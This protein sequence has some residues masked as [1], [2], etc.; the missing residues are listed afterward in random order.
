MAEKLALTSLEVDNVLR[1]KAVRLSMIGDSLVIEGA[2][3][4][5]K[6]SVLKSLEILLA[7]M[8]ETPPEP[9]HGDAK[10]GEIIATFTVPDDPDD[11]AFSDITQI[12]IRKTFTRGKTPAL[13]VTSEGKKLKK[14]QTVLNELLDRVSLRPRKFMAM[15]DKEKLDTLSAIMEFDASEFDEQYQELYDKRREA[16]RDAKR[17][18]A[19]ADA[20]TLHKGAERPLTEVNV[21]DLLK[22]LNERETE[23]TRLDG[24]DR[25]VAS[26][27]AIVSRLDDECVEAERR[28][29]SLREQRREAVA[30]Y[31]Q[32]GQARGHD[33]PCE[34]QSIKDQIATADERNRKVRENA[35]H[36]KKHV[37]LGK[38]LDYVE[39]LNAEMA[40]I[41]AKKERAREKARDRLPV[42]DLDISADAVLYKGKPLSQAGTSAQLRISVAIAIALNKDN[43]IKLL[44]VDDAETLD[45]KNT[46][47]LLKLAKEAGFQV[48]MARV[49]DGKKSSV[50]IEDG[51]IE[52]EE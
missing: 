49:G 35:E 2:N 42:P 41:E 50:L 51:T 5:G 39:E 47:L 8:S 23:N 48:L 17:L 28:L 25:D 4:Q 31:E 11:P 19:E 13:S 43:R 6:S 20:C 34:T 44:L 10:K 3:E 16:S 32:A 9:I 15:S 22:E 18:K 26:A 7:G 27:G 36:E 14:P 52:P 12:V 30:A 33:G 24:L 45:K 37:A 40:D 21:A 46:K 29:E 1:L 38:K